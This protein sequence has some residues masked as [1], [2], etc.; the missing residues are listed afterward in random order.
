MALFAEQKQIFRPVCCDRTTAWMQEL[1]QCK[2]QL[3]RRVVYFQTASKLTCSFTFNKVPMIHPTAVI[4]DDADIGDNV[5]IGPYS[6]I[7]AGVSIGEG[8]H[9]GSHVV[10]HGPCKIGRE[11]RIHSFASLGDSPQDISF[12]NSQHTSL[13]IGDHNEIRE[14]VSIHRGAAK[15]DYIT[16]V[17]SHNL[18]MAYV[19]I[20]HNCQLGNHIVMANTTDLSG[21]VVVGDYATI[22]GQSGVHQFCR[23]G[24]YSMVGGCSRVAQDILPFV[25]YAKDAPKS[26]NS[27]GLKRHGFSTDQIQYIKRAY[28]LIYRSRSCKEALFLDL[29][30][31]SQKADDA[32][33]HI[34]LMIREMKA[35]TRGWGC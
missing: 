32:K 29:V 23:I 26:I 9:I 7:R 6:V 35:S 31:L 3:P 33:G 15:D 11:N 17:G 34:E 19:H 18:L 10:I 13:E 5:R 22:G 25:M 24:S 20:G 16:R 12:D 4:D 27:I 21:H 14:Y 2:E 30:E 28:K 1:E 8:T